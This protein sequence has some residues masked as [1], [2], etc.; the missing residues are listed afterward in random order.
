MGSLAAQ[1]LLARIEGEKEGPPEILIEPE[2]VVRHST[3]KAPNS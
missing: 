3:A 2:L 1:T